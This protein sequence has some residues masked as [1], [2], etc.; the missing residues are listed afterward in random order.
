MSTLFGKNFEIFFDQLLKP[1]PIKG[2]TRNFFL[3]FLVVGQGGR[4][5][6]GKIG[7]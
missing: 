6:L 3:F 1:F 7:F 4:L 2:F 5:E